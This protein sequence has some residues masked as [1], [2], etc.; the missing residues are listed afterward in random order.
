[1]KNVSIHNSSS[2]VIS[3]ISY[4]LFTMQLASNKI[5]IGKSVCTLAYHSQL[6]IMIDF[7]LFSEVLINYGVLLLLVCLINALFRALY[8]IVNTI[9][10]IVYFVLENRQY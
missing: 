9:A 8:Y 6:F 7:Y 5:K 4:G 1:M 3:K 10:C 2:R